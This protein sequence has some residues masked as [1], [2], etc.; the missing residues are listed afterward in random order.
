M[1]FSDAFKV[2]QLNIL[3]QAGVMVTP[4]QIGLKSDPVV[5][6]Q[7]KNSTFDN[8]LGRLGGSGIPGLPSLPTPPVPPA[9]T[10]DAA[11]QTQY[12]QD[13]LTYNHQFQLYNQRLM[14]MLLTQLQ[15]I[16]KS[17]Q[18]GQQNAKAT[19]DSSERPI[20]IGGILSGMDV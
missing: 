18:A 16:Q 9:N 6:L 12:Q 5:D 2:F 11:A 19:S 20:G 14:Q 15:A 8:I 3:R 13:L 4:Q 10:A 1:N 7:A 17:V